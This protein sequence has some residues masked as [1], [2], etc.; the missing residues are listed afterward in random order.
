M[1]LKDLSCLSDFTYTQ[2]YLMENLLQNLVSFLSGSCFSKL[3][4]LSTQSG[5]K[6]KWPSWDMCVLCGTH[7]MFGWSIRLPF[8]KG[9]NAKHIVF[10]HQFAFPSSHVGVSMNGSQWSTNVLRERQ[11][12]AWFWKRARRRERIDVNFCCT[13][14]TSNHS[15][16]KKV[17][18]PLLFSLYRKWHKAPVFL[19]LSVSHA[20]LSL[21]LPLSLHLSLS[22]SSSLSPHLF[23]SVHLFFLYDCLSLPLSVSLCLFIHF[24]SSAPLSHSSRLFLLIVCISLS[25]YLSS[26]R[27]C[28]THSFYL[29]VYPFHVS[30]YH[31]LSLFICISLSF[32]VCLSLC[33][34]SLLLIGQPW[35]KCAFT[36]CCRWRRF[37][38]LD[39]VRRFCSGMKKNEMNRLQG[40]E[41][42]G[43]ISAALPLAGSRHGA[44]WILTYLY[45]FK[46]KLLW[47]R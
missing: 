45:L 34:F 20:H 26:S 18:M 5:I 28:P 2:V 39:A 47:Q 9:V 13:A 44:K 32:S 41:G 29:I 35:W 14:L 38:L 23:I 10:P 7:V 11:Q 21:H 4:K 46:L 25:V 22:Q 1:V 43:L 8:V 12:L 17:K 15:L 24:V 6:F 31:P 33:F 37:G 19:A 3:R 42:G 16:K 27:M 40:G 30:L 36:G